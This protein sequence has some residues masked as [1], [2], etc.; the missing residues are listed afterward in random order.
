MKYNWYAIKLV[1]ITVIIFVFQ[2]LIP[3]LTDEY[4]LVSSEFLSKPW[5]IVTY[6]F[7]HATDYLPHILFN[8]LALALF[9]SI[10]E[11]IIGGRKFL[12][13]YFASGIVAGLGSILFYIASIGASGA[14]FGILG[15]LA[16]LRPRMTV[17][18]GYVPMPMVFAVLIWIAGNFMGLFAPGG[19]A[20][21]AHLFGLAFGLI[22][23]FLLRKDY[24]ENAPIKR[25]TEDMDEEEFR[26]WEDEWV[27]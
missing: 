9:G 17:W 3:S 6:M 23:G 2:L 16:V 7:L 14:I 15:A 24:G 10:L 18:I 21:A 5:T 1:I 13:I 8:M 26:E 25:K 22:Y 19:I 20:Y 27:R 11:K 12:I 4:A